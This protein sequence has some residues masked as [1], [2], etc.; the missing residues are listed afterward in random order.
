MTL[1]LALLPLE[2]KTLYLYY[3]QSL[4]FSLRSYLTFPGAVIRCSDKATEGERVDDFSSQFMVVHS[5]LVA[6]AR[7]SKG[8]KQ[9]GHPPS[10]LS[11]SMSPGSQAGDG[12]I[13]QELVNG[14][15][16]RDGVKGREI[17]FSYKKKHHPPHPLPWEGDG[18]PTQHLE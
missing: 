12:A 1:G 2:L 10:W 18:F 5:V 16:V 8:L 3:C 13:S 15:A 4:G 14:R 9:V 17:I 7:A 11:P 6:E